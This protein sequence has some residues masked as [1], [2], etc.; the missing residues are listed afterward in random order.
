MRMRREGGYRVGAGSPGLL[1]PLLQQDKHLGE[2]EA[3]LPA[4]RAPAREFTLVGIAAQRGLAEAED[5]RRF[6][7]CEVGIHEPVDDLIARLRERW[8]PHPAG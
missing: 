7:Q 2:F 3:A 8:A 1:A 5:R 6:V 4:C